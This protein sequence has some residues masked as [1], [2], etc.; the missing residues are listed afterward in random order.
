MHGVNM[1][2]LTIIPTQRELD[3]FIQA[4][5]ES[6]Q[7]SESAVTGKLPLTAFPALSIAVAHGGLGKTQFAV[8]TQ[9]LI[10]QRPWTL[11]ICAGTSGALVDD[12]AV[13]DVVIA[14]ET[15]EHDF[16][17]GFGSLRVPRFPS[18]DHIL[19][20]CRDALRQT[21][22]TFQVHYAP[23]ASGDEDVMEEER[24]AA[25]RAHTGA[26]VC[27]WEGAGGARASQFSDV[28]FV[29]IRGVTDNANPDAAVDFKLNVKA[30]MHNVAQVIVSLAQWHT[31]F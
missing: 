15:V 2:I 9:H 30:A 14:T 7:D 13:G 28:P 27:A 3:G 24:R 8:H 10:E 22:H 25:I 16:R 26:V 1:N 19:A 11:V 4:C 5:H 23:I 21:E 18:A 12:V 20:R 29:E 31:A 6:G 17:N